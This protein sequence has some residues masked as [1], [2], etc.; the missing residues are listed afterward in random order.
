MLLMSSIVLFI[1]EGKVTE[2]NITN[3]LSNFFLNE[4]GNRLLKASYGFNIY[5]L[6]EAL[7]NDQGLDLYEIIVEEL[8]KRERKTAEDQAVIDIQDFSKIS[9]IYLFFDYDCHC[10]NADDDKL[11]EMLSTFNNSQ[12]NGL[13]H[14]SYPMVEAIRHQKR[15]AYEYEVH[16]TGNLSEYKNWVN[17]E[18]RNGTLDS[19]YQNWGLYNLT[20]WEAISNV[21]LL[22]ANFLLN[23]EFVRPIE[24][25][26]P[27]DIFRSQKDKNIP[28]QE[29]T[30]L[31]SFPLMLHEFY[32]SELFDKFMSED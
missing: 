23:D 17:E 25:A 4:N 32:G 29:V 22:R 21:N 31:S 30:V 20:T 24:P 28:N 7:N 18:I 1:F 11:E 16:S 12:E 6:H 13:L 26:Q 3:N 15:V 8:N 2:P 10:S 19:K 14:I 5:K 9:D 27:F